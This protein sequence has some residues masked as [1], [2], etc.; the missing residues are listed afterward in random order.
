M[1]EFHLFPSFLI[2]IFFQDEPPTNWTTPEQMTDKDLEEAMNAGKEALGDREMFEES[3][4]SPAINTPSFR[5]Q[6]AVGTTFEA[7]IA[8]RRGYVEDHA[9]RHLAKRF[10]F[11]RKYHQR[12][13]FGVG[14]KSNLT[15]ETSIE[16]N[17]FQKFRTFDG[18]CNNKRNPLWGSAMMP[19]RRAMNPDYCDGISSPRCAVD[20]SELPSAR[21]ISTE[22]HRP[23]YRT[24][25]HFT[26]MLAVWGQFLDHDI[27]ATA[28]SS[29][30]DGRP[31]EC[32]SGSQ[33]VHPECFPVP[34]GKGD[35][36]F[37][38]FNITCM[39]F[40]RSIPAPTNRL[41][42]RQQFNQASSFIDGS[43]VYGPTLEKA[44]QLRSGMNFG[45]NF[46]F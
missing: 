26:V 19:F 25:Q 6:K 32:C 17:E 21:Q 18:K 30:I 37:D 27:T 22:I 46:K 10:N 45:W 7:R 33:P 28:L 39:N 9:T 38:Q 20:G 23:S 5:A 11:A 35:Y 8:S 15:K 3:M 16:C 44:N 42:V 34:V 41:G 29:S 36:F 12:S 40:V 24:E 2:I 13:S 14:P 31:I 1:P 4:E 43:V